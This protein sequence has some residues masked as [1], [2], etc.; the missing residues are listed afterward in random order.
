MARQLLRFSL[1]MLILKDHMCLDGRAIDDFLAIDD[2]NIIMLANLNEE[3]NSSAPTSRN[4][5]YDL[6]A[7]ASCGLREVVVLGGDRGTK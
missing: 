3:L 1:R 4:D 7:M 6:T 5:T 2:K